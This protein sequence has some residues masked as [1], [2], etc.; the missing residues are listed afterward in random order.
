VDPAITYS[1]FALFNPPTSSN[2]N[3]RFPFLPDRQVQH[4]QISYESDVLGR[5]RDAAPMEKSQCPYPDC[6]KIFKDL[7]AHM[8]THQFER[9]EKCPIATCDYHI[10][11]FARKYDKNRHTL[12][13]YK[14]TMVCGFCPG[15]GTA[16]EKTFN[17]S[18]VFKR[19][20]T[21][22]HGVEQ[23]PPNSRKRKPLAEENKGKKLIP[24]PAPDAG[25]KCSICAAKFDNAQD[26]YEH[27]DDCVLDSIRSLDPFGDTPP[28]HVDRYTQQV[29]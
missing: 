22:Y 5:R 19:H 15:S 27:L 1:S 4:G 7:K 12:T 16:A 2:N 20:L 29:S 10:K 25:T 8:L 26:F 18:D 13:H 11:G 24:I 28:V 23:S 9:P 3:H 21:S 14:G 6:G 17:R